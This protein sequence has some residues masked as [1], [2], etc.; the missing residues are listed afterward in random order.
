[1]TLSYVKTPIRVVVLA[2]RLCRGVPE[3]E[4]EPYILETK[5]ARISFHPIRHGLCSSHA[6]SCDEAKLATP[7][8]HDDTAIWL[9]LRLEAVRCRRRTKERRCHRRKKERKSRTC[10]SRNRATFTLRPAQ[11][12]PSQVLQMRRSQL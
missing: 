4:F 6:V 2:D 1:M 3:R 10:W 5:L 11:L 7:L 12:L 8:I 9:R